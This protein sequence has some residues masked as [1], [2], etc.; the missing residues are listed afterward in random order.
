[1]RILYQR[2]QN[3]LSLPSVSISSSARLV[4]GLAVCSFVAQGKASS[5]E[6][7]VIQN[8]C[9]FPVY[10]WAADEPNAPTYATVIQAQSNYTERLESSC[11]TILVKLSKTPTTNNITSFEYA[12]NDSLSYYDIALINCVQAQNEAVCPQW[13]HGPR[14]RRGNGKDV[15]GECYCSGEGLQSHQE[16]FDALETSMA[17]GKSS[18]YTQGRLPKATASST[19][20]TKTAMPTATVIKEFATQSRSQQVSSTQITNAEQ[21]VLPRV[22]DSWTIPP[23]CP[24]YIPWPLPSTPM[25]VIDNVDAPQ[26]ILFSRP[27]VVADRITIFNYCKY[28][29]W[30]GPY[31]GNILA[32][33]EHVPAGGKFDWQL[34]TASD[35]SGNN[36]KVSKV[37]DNFTHPVQI[38]YTVASGRVW[39]DISLIDCLGRTGEMKRGKVV[40]NGDTRACAGHEA[41]LQLGNANAMTFQCGPG[42]WCD[43]QAYMYE[44]SLCICF[45][46]DRLTLHLPGESLQEQESHVSV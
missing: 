12:L 14:L 23:A 15:C 10:L 29:L 42:V 22:K 27:V 6:I 43:D 11:D 39:Y 18:R 16:N 33:V 1:M 46:S 21:S 19:F 26:L 2:I 45:Q 13:E 30:V 3:R 31:F 38:E 17:W 24:W 40:R 35:G 28:D 20:D 25:P 32:E 44:V 8:H 41:G 4:L 34:T 9:S 7:A 37:K 5:V 36:L